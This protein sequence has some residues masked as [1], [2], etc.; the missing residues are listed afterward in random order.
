MPHIATTAATVAATTTTHGTTFY[1]SPAAAAQPSLAGKQSPAAAAKLLP[2]TSTGRPSRIHDN[3]LVAEHLSQYL[4]FTDFMQDAPG[5]FRAALDDV[6]TGATQLDLGG[7][8][9][10]L[11]K[12][13]LFT[14]LAHLPVIS[15]GTT[16]EAL[17][18]T[19]QH[20]RKVAA[21]LRVASTALYEW[22][23]RHMEMNAAGEEVQGNCHLH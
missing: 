18:C 17:Q 3:S 15:T 1:A 23:V 12:A 11:G 9:R 21:V 10:P 7:N 6:I 8:S 22:I 14:L 13:R 2:V 20:A 16:A 4:D 19:E 5:A